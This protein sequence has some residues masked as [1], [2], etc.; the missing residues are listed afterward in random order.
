MTN[1]QIFD[2][3]IDLRR[4]LKTLSHCRVCDIAEC[5]CS[6]CVFVSAFLLPTAYLYVIDCD[7]I[8]FTFN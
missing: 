2:F 8:L 3:L 7:V 1:G 6:T 5:V 4:R